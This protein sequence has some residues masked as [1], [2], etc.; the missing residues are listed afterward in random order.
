MQPAEPLLTGYPWQ[1][2]VPAAARC[3]LLLLFGLV[4]QFRLQ[5]LVRRNA[6][7]FFYDMSAAQE[8]VRWARP[9]HLLHIALKITPF[10]TRC[11]KCVIL[12]GA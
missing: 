2:R 9:W 11:A 7:T 12:S 8:H 1:A 3:G 4:L 5:E 10:G 6:F